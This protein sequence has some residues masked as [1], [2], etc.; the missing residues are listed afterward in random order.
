[1]L[2]RSGETRPDGLT[3]QGA[4]GAD[5]RLTKGSPAIDAGAK[6]FYPWALAA[7]VGEWHFTENHADAKIVTD[8]AL[9]MSEVH[10]NRFMYNQV[11]THSIQL[12]RAT[13]SDYAASPSEDWGHGAMT[14]DGKR[15]GKVADADM[16]A[17]FELELAGYVNNQGQRTYANF[18]KAVNREIWKVPEPDIR[19]RGQP[20]FSEGKVAVYPGQR[21]NTLIS[22]TGNLLLE[23]KFKTDADH[24]DG[25]LMA[26]HDG[27]SGY[28]L[29]V[30]D[31]GR[32]EFVISAGGADARVASAEKINDGK[33]HHVLAEIN[34]KAGRMTMYVDGKV[35]S[36]ANATLMPDASIDCKADFTVGKSSAGDAG[37]LKGAIDF[38]R[39]CHATLADSKTSIEELYA[40]QYINGPALFDMRGRPAQGQ[41][42]D[43]GA[44]ER[45]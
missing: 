19:K 31:Q 39:I 13:L 17:D 30:N 29:K 8:Y 10:F 42:R 32:A 44:L 38:M 34:R 6:Y 15:F 22:K 28:A 18:N 41:G 5:F 37:Y 14:F 2:F 11:P 25:V 40:W 24:T 21:R 45:E 35:S 23:A 27:Q 33:W 1:V 7:T 43:A 4:F 26:K 36:R 9:F 3:E 16:R 12:N 20:A